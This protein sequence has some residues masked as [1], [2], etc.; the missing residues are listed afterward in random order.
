MRTQMNSSKYS[1]YELWIAG[2][3]HPFYVGKGLQG[4]PYKHLD[5]ARKG[6]KSHKSNKIRKAW[7][8]NLPIII[9]HVLRTDIEQEAFNEEKRL[10]SYYGRRDKKTGELINV[11][12]GGE[13]TSG[14]VHTEES[15]K[16]MKERRK[17]Y[18]ITEETRQKLREKSLGKRHSEETIQKLRESSTGRHHS[19]ETKKKVGDFHRGKVVTEETRQKLRE[20]STGK[21][22]SEETRQ[23]MKNSQTRRRMIESQK[24]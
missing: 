12:D 18:V 8:E 9:K 2:E 14:H 1:V 22:I 11:T 15:R 5:A 23:K 4:R 3:E 19:E 13:G 10:I 17:E 24:R 6:E 20:I 21:H 16:K 7:R